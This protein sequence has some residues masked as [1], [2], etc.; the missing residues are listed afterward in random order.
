MRRSSIPRKHRRRCHAAS[1]AV[2][3]TAIFVLYSF[4]R[5]RYRRAMTYTTDN[6]R[7]ATPEDLADA[8]AFALRFKGRKR[9]ND[10]G[11]FMASIV[12]KRLVEH[13]EQSGFVIMRKPPA[14]GGAALLRGHEG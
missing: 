8:L 1:R 10:A 3:N 11:E 12:A 5:L 9:V 2:G 4:S 14:V 6:L 13:L 7:P